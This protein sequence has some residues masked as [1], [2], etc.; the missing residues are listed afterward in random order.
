MTDR[1]DRNMG[2][3]EDWEDGKMGRWE[4]G[5]FGPRRLLVSY[6]IYKEVRKVLPTRTFRGCVPQELFDVFLIV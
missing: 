5:T 3:W 4:D 2:R 6:N 1:E